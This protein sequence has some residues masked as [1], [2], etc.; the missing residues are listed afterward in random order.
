MSAQL[1]GIALGLSISGAVFLN[2]AINGL[3]KVLPDVSRDQIQTAVL[4]VS[5]N[6]FRTLPADVRRNATN[7]IVDAIDRTF[8]LHTPFQNMQLPLLLGV[9]A[10]EKSR[11]IIVL[12]SGIVGFLSATFMT[13]SPNLTSLA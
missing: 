12:V 3:S 2:K 8:V 6:L 4:G 10:D 13:V 1:L 11:Y 7:V 9:W 5:G